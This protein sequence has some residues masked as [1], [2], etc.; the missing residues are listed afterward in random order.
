MNLKAMVIAVGIETTGLHERIA[1]K[2]IL[3]FG[4]NPLWYKL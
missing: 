1:L 2:I 4:S 3:L